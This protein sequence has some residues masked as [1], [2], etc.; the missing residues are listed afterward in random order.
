[1]QEVVTENME[2]IKP[3]N[4]VQRIVES[5]LRVL[6]IDDF[7]SYAQVM[8]N[9]IFVLAIVF[10]G[11]LEIFNTHLAVRLNRNINKKQDAIKELRWEYM[12]VKTDMNQKSKQSEL[13]Q[14]LAPYGIKALQEPPKKIEVNKDALI[15]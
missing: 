4:K 3:T 1:M 13:Q 12:T 9:F 11:V 7:I 10:I 14:I 6:G 5:M 2:E 8:H 15:K